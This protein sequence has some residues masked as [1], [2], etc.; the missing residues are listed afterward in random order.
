MTK[1]TLFAA[2]AVATL[3]AAAPALGA[4]PTVAYIDDG[5][6]WFAAADGTQ[7]RQ[8]TTSGTAERPFQVPSQGPDGTTVVVKREEFDN[9]ASVR[10]VL[11]R[12]GADGRMTHG[13]VLPV[14]SGA[15]APVYPIGLDMDW[16]SNAVAYGHQ[17]CGFACR[18]LHRG[19]WL[20][21]A[22]NQGAYPTNPQGQSDAHFPTFYGTRVISS[23]SGGSLF[24]QP[25]V[26]E[27]PF[28]SSYQGWLSG[29]DNGV[30][31]RRAEVAM[32]G[33]QVA[34][35]WYSRTSGDSANGILVGEHAGAIPG[36]IANVCSL[37]TAGAASNVTFSYDGALVA[38]QDDG[39]VKVAG[40][41]NLAAG[42]TTCT[43]S[44]PVRIISPTGKAPHLGGADPAAWS[45]SGGGTTPPLSGTTATT[46]GGGAAGGRPGT[47]A[48]TG[49]GQD[50][51]HANLVLRAPAAAT[52]RVLRKGLVL[53][54]EV[55][56]AGRVDATATLPAAAAKR[57]KLRGADLRVVAASGSKRGGAVVARGSGRP[58]RAGAARVTLKLTP[59]ATRQLARLRGTTLQI[60]IS[61]GTATAHGAIRVR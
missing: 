18:T 52:R 26:P 19:F 61:Q 34:L 56:K 54:V 15:T 31:F 23:D 13:N 25:D 48:S 24:V 33:H 32:T 22:D 58:T 30:N 44:A 45:G 50:V 17:Y 35:E 49:P 47:S 53:T 57:L 16:R 14:Y 6:L 37:P 20:T 55:P 7:K 59:A 41:P 1:R 42:T 4:G 10:P 60:R 2:T 21:F 3:A 11:Y 28:T 36:S 39:G 8:L 43:L 9:G 5:N 29:P 51:A 40:A 38:W 12:Y 46:P 27:A